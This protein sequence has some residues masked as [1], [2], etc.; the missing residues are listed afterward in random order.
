L[1]VFLLFILIVVIFIRVIWKV[2]NLLLID[3]KRKIQF[4]EEVSVY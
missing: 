2:K 4:N 3:I 1:Q